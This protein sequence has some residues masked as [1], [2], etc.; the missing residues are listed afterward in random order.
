MLIFNELFVVYKYNPEIEF[1]I[2]ALYKTTILFI[3]Y[4]IVSMITRYIWRF[5]K[6]VSII[7]FGPFAV[8]V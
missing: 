1:F 3:C 2:F 4:I 7:H 6:L 5:C 8:H